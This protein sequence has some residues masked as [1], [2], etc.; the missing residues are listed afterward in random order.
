MEK[1]MTKTKTLESFKRDSVERSVVQDR[2]ISGY[3]NKKYQALIYAF[4]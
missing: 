4:S 1:K 2:L 3:R